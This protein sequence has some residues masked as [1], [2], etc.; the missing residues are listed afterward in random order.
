[1][2][3]TSFETTTT[4]TRS[5]IDGEAQ[6]R[7]ERRIAVNGKGSVCVTASCIEVRDGYG[8]PDG[9]TLIYWADGEEILSAM[10]DYVAALRREV[11]RAA[12]RGDLTP[13][14][15]NPT[16]V[17]QLEN[18]NRILGAAGLEFPFA[19]PVTADA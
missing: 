1:M 10:V 2:L 6:T 14:S 7:T 13:G 18:L 19:L 5:A 11:E 12:D 17:R 8:E 3:R 16:A 4:E 15:E 9:L